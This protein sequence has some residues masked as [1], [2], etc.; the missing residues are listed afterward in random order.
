MNHQVNHDASHDSSRQMSR[1]MRPSSSAPFKTALH[2]A[3]PRAARKPIRGSKSVSA[4]VRAGAGTLAVL[5]VSACATSP[6]GRRQFIIV[7]EGQMTVMGAEAFQQLKTQQKLNTDPRT[8]QYVKCI[9]REITSELGS[10]EAPDNWE[11]VVFEDSSPNAFALPGGKIGVHTGML[12]VAESPAQLAAVIGHEVGHVLARHGAERVSE[13][14]ATQGGL[15][16]INLILSQRGENY[17]LL[18]GALGLGAQFGVLLPHSRT[19]ES[20]ADTIGL[21]LMAKAG[22]DPRQSVALWRNMEKAGGGQPPEFLSTHP[23][24]GTRIENLQAHMSEAEK[25]YEKNPDKP[26]CSL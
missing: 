26:K 8:N 2:G 25:L 12:K 4:L 14:F 16:A 20:E 21:D 6:E 5:A 23:S 13:N 15:A 11:V 24:H 17:D 19:Q 18:M 1:A 9:A 3:A 10:D 7:P 22:F